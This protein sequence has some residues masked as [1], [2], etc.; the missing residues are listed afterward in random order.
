MLPSLMILGFLGL[1]FGFG[2]FIASRVF[3][4][5]V[6]VR[7]ARVEHAL[8]GANCGACGLAGCGAFAKAIVHG[9]A[10]ITGC[11]PGGDSVAHLVADIM[12][13]EAKEVE[14]DVAILRCQGKD[15]QDRYE[16]QGV[17]TCAAAALI[18]G[19]PKSCLEGCIGFG[20]CCKVCPFDALHMKDGLPVV[21]EAKCKSCGKCV[22]ACPKGLFDLQPIGKLVHVRC[23]NHELGKFVRKSC[24][25]GCIACKKC[26]KICKFD[27]V[28]IENNL[29]VFDYEKC[30]SCGLCVKECPTGTIV[31]LRMERKTIGLWPIKKKEE[32]KTEAVESDAAQ[33]QSE[34]QS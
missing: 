13:V 34:A 29:A 33:P 4:V 3:R 18:H 5:N 26:E 11:I 24:A 20:D 6:D 15:V 22:E 16:Y 17:K 30:V 2:L 10:D 7:I 21:D 25:V 9:S 23:K 12:G 14:K 31:N 1:L 32:V 28:H 27:A 19:G 8:P